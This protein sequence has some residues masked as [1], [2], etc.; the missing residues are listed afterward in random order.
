MTLHVYTTPDELSTQGLQGGYEGIALQGFICEERADIRVHLSN[1]G[2]GTKIV[3]L[4]S[5]T[6][7]ICL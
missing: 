1:K 2:R 3:Q 5:R 6:A 7:Q 4:V